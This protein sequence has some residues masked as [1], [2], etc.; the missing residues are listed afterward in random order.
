MVMIWVI[1]IIFTILIT[2]MFPNRMVMIWVITIIF[3]ILITHMFPIR[4]VMIWVITIIFTICLVKPTIIFT[5]LIT[6]FTMIWVSHS[7]VH[8]FHRAAGPTTLDRTCRGGAAIRS[9]G[10]LV[11]KWADAW[12]LELGW[13]TV[14]TIL[15]TI[16]NSTI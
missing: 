10:S 14:F 13:F 7:H 16:K 11:E 15:Y 3:T 4:M 2:H 5:I 12:V 8:R 9:E 6:I 1:T